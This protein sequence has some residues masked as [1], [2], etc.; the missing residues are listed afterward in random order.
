MSQPQPPKFTP[1]YR[2]TLNAV[3]LRVVEREAQETPTQLNR[4]AKFIAQ[5]HLRTAT[6]DARGKR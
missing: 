5:Q 6:D 3:I 4:D 1:E 2:V